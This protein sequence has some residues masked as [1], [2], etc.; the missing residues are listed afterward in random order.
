MELIRTIPALRE[1][2]QGEASI[3]L[4]PTMGSLHAGHVSLVDL[5]RTRGGCVV[6]SIFVNRLQF[7]PGGDFD[8]YPR[9]LERDLSMLEAAGVHTVFAPEEQE[10]YPGPQEVV[11]SPPRLADTLEG[12]YRP[13]HFQG[14]STVVAKLF[15]AVRP[16]IAVFG[17]KDYQQLRVIMAMERQL[18]FGIRILPAETVREPDG[19]AMSS[20]NAYLSEAE[21]AE[22]VRLNRTLRRIKETVEGGSRDFGSLEKSAEAELSKAGWGVDYIA[23]RERSGLRAP[24][25]GD[26]QLVVLGAARIGRTRLIDN[27]EIGA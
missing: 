22:A 23:I 25:A 12:V 10:M 5:A 9:S 1:R 7:E 27:L 15:N 8:R 3:A 13:G 18:N 21:R 2:L 17:K 6:A 14:V 4:V 20:R 19:L 26:S 24:A 16:H 11:V